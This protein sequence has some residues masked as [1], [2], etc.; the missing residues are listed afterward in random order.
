MKLTPQLC[1]F[2][3]TFL[4]ESSKETDLNQLVADYAPIDLIGNGSLWLANQSL[5]RLGLYTYHY[6]PVETRP[7]GDP[8]PR[9]A[10]GEQA[11]RYVQTIGEIAIYEYPSGH[12][13]RGGNKEVRVNL[14][15]SWPYAIMQSIQGFRVMQKVLLP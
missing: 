3:L 5:S 9:C 1:E 7:L 11:P 4:E 8:L 13:M 12:A 6:A 2:A 14:Q 15:V 10:C